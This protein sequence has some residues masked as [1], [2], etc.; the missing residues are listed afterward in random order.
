MIS[1]YSPKK[2][3]SNRIDRD[4]RVNKLFVVIDSEYLSKWQTKKNN[5][6][7]THFKFNLSISFDVYDGLYILVH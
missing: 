1:T 5:L 3:K 7:R 4:T 6:S 2:E